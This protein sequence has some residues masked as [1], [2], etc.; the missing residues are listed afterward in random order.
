LFSG[1]RNGSKIGGAFVILI[2]VIINLFGA[3]VKLNYFVCITFKQVV[4]K[5]FH[6]KILVVII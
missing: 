6:F 4:S 5:T 2:P 3:F 1:F